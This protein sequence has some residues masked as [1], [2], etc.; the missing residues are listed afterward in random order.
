MKR[1]KITSERL[2]ALRRQMALRFEFSFGHNLTDQ[3]RDQNWQEYQNLRNEY[4]SE[5]QRLSSPTK[6]T[7]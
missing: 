4:L 3:E 6:E 1:N 5:Y 7:K 2:R